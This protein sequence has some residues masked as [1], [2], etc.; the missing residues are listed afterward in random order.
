MY[1]SRLIATGIAS[2]MLVTT[3]SAD[4]N[5]RSTGSHNIVV[6][7]NS[8]TMSLRQAYRKGLIVKKQKYPK[9]LIALARG[10]GDEIEDCMKNPDNK[11]MPYIERLGACF[12]LA[13]NNEPE[14]CQ[15]AD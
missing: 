4:V 8:K 7:Q 2:I 10:S 15:S 11:N 14:G 12:C 5:K 3:A 6:A 9:N 13:T 1:I